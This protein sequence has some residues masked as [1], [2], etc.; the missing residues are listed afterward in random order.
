MAN[1][2][3]EQVLVVERVT[4]I[5]GQRRAF[6]VEKERAL[7]AAICGPLYS[8]TASFTVNARLCSCSKVNQR[9]VMPKMVQPRFLFT[10]RDRIL[11]GH[12]RQ[13]TRHIE[14]EFALDA[15]IG[16]RPVPPGTSLACSRL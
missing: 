14:M 4:E 13:R 15:A 7:T 16:Y 1:L 12:G 2:E 5:W 9:M 3:I 8:V 11:A 10:P 6:H